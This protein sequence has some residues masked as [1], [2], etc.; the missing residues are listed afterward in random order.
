MNT[1][2]EKNKEKLC[3]LIFSTIYLVKSLRNKNI[4]NIE[5]TKE[6]VYLDSQFL[7]KIYANNEIVYVKNLDEKIQ[8][9]YNKNQKWRIIQFYDYEGEFMYEIEPYFESN[10]I[11][12][13]TK[14]SVTPD[15]ILSSLEEEKIVEDVNTF[16][17][18]Y[19]NS[20]LL[21]VIYFC[22]YN[23][24][25]IISKNNA[26]IINL[27]LNNQILFDK[28]MKK[29][30]DMNKSYFTDLNFDMNNL[31]PS[32]NNIIKNIQINILKI[33]NIQSD[34]SIC[35]LS[36]SKQLQEIVMTNIMNFTSNYKIQFV[37]KEN[38][39]S[40]KLN[41]DLSVFYESYNKLSIPEIPANIKI[42]YI[43][44]Y[45]KNI[46]ESNS[47]D[48]FNIFCKT[49][50]INSDAMLSVLKYNYNASTNSLINYNKSKLQLKSGLTQKERTDMKIN[51]NSNLKELSVSSGGKKSKKNKKS[52]HNGSKKIY[53]GGL[54]A[55][56]ALAAA[57]Q[58]ITGYIAASEVAA[59][60]AAGCA[61]V[62][63]GGGLIAGGG[64]AVLMAAPVAAATS[65]IWIPI[66]MGGAAVLAGGYGV[67]NYFSPDVAQDI[68]EEAENIIDPE[69]LNEAQA[70]RE[71]NAKMIQEAREAQIAQKVAAEKQG[72]RQAQ[73]EGQKQADIRAR[74]LQ[75]GREQL[76][77]NREFKQKERLEV[78]EAEIAQ[79]VA[80]EKQAQRQAQIEG[81]NQADIR[82]R[83][84]QPGQEELIANRE[85]KIDA[86]REANE[87]NWNNPPYKSTYQAPELG[88][89]ANP[90]FDYF[91][92]PY[93]STYQPPELGTSV[94]PDWGLS[95]GNSNM[96]N[97]ETG[98]CSLPDVP[99][100]STY[101]PQGMP[102][103]NINNDF[104]NYNKFLPAGEQ[105]MLMPQQDFTDFS[106]VG[107]LAVLGIA[108]IFFAKKMMTKSS[109]PPL[110]PKP[111]SK[112]KPKKKIIDDGE[113]N[114]S[115][116]QTPNYQDVDLYS[117]IKEQ[118]PK[119]LSFPSVPTNVPIPLPSVPTNDPIPVPI[120]KKIAITTSGEAVEVG[121]KTRKRKRKRTKKY[122]KKRKY[123]M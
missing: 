6:V 47:I 114:E 58:G 2:V 75:P 1:F 95:Y 38:Y 63:P 90:E 102:Q 33:F 54:W 71:S 34:E 92:P 66:A 3:S 55:V 17:E 21:Y 16:R 7:N 83:E 27:F 48:L 18:K 25:T 24:V 10:I 120:K 100:Y 72:Q 111:K 50:N 118:T 105:Q 94:N 61:V 5:Y 26:K 91:N 14:I 13:N 116:D 69:Q 85:A 86:R 68:M 121:G 119:P 29:I 112:L 41:S 20:F 78:R 110:K 57:A 79:N 42:N 115:F 37:K 117:S 15:K 77:A 99:Y 73:I 64:G 82:A 98:M 96:C 67:Y 51:T 80:A 70:I 101:Q 30:I 65:P 88:T 109:P 84:P 53:K 59:A 89:S 19:E 49:F 9:K 104:N 56:A 52:K 35:D 31:L 106:T 87:F 97:A 36:K 103:L 60:I 62:A 46:S 44:P 122:T 28:L 113:S 23:C 123:K 40:N 93:K 11:T 8:K 107:S 76:D 74:E 43:T 81:H 39:E 108:G 4:K 12:N 32:I 22:F 45:G